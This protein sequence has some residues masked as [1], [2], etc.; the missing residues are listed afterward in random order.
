MFVPMSF[1]TILNHSSDCDEI[2]YRDRLDLVEGDRLFTKKVNKRSKKKRLSIRDSNRSLE[3]EPRFWSTHFL[4]C[5]NIIFLKKMLSINSWYSIQYNFC[6]NDTVSK[7]GKISLLKY[8][9]PPAATHS[10]APRVYQLYLFPLWYIKAYNELVTLYNI[11][12]MHG[13]N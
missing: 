8:I 11:R 10:L 3:F 5:S 4:R 7:N 1:I 13:H 9:S 2:W 12:S 6:N